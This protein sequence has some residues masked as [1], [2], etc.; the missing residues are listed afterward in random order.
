MRERCP[1]CGTF[2]P[3]LVT[4]R[5]GNRRCEA[6][7]DS[8]WRFSAE[9][10]PEAWDASVPPGKVLALLAL[11]MAAVVGVVWGLSR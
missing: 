8:W 9:H 6:C 2:A 3:Y 11:V 1:S 4:G 10:E 5:D 7:H